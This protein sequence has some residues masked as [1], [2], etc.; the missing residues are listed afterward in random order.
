MISGRISLNYIEVFIEKDA[1]IGVIEGIC[2]QYEVPYLACRG[3]AS[4]SEIWRAGHERMRMRLMKDQQV[5]VLYLGD[6]D[7]S[8]IDMTRD[9]RERLRQFSNGHVLPLQVEVVRLALNKDQVDEYDPPPNPTKLSDSRAEDYV[10]VYGHECWELDAMSP[11][12]IRDLVEAAILDRRDEE[13]WAEAV[14][15]E[16]EG[17]RNTLPRWRRI[18]M[19]WSLACLPSEEMICQA[20]TRPHSSRFDKATNLIAGSARKF[21]AAINAEAGP[22]DIPAYT[23]G[24]DD[25]N[26]YIRIP[27]PAYC[28][29]I[30]RDLWRDVYYPP[31]LEPGVFMDTDPEA[32]VSSHE[33][34]GAT[35]RLY[36]Q[37]TPEDRMTV[38][39]E[40]NELDD[41]ETKQA[42]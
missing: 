10:A 25:N 32:T 19:M 27:V 4:A 2:N 1:L 31:Q 9:I 14:E 29:K 11:T 16:A 13:L 6:H 21:V 3:Y 5:T 20:T 34:I 18:G 40:L 30:A 26:P 17:S 42:S 37:L 15:R 38:L 7:P 33:M 22:G 39:K 12:V 24:E 23:S 8:G 28:L 35:L 36:R 41:I